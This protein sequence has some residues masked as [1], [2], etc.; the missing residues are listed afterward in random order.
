MEAEMNTEMAY[1]VAFFM[2][3]HVFVAIFWIHW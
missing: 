3:L 1:Y 2:K